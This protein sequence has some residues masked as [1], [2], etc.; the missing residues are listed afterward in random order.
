MCDGAHG[1]P[2]I[3]WP[4]RIAEGRYSFDGEE[5]QLALSEPARANAIHGL[6]RWRPWRVGARTD[7]RVVMEARLLPMTG[8]PF[9]LE[10]AIS[11]ALDEEGLTVMTSATNAGELPCPLG[12]G[13]HPYLSPGA[14][15]R[16]DGCVLTLAAATR[17]LTDE[18]HQVPVSREPVEGTAF[19]FRAGRELGSAS[20]DD[21]FTELERDREGLAR[22]QLRRPDGSTVELWVDGSY[23]FLEVFT[24]DTLPAARRRRGL[25]LEPMSCAPNAFRSGEGLL[26]LAPGETFTGS[27]GVRLL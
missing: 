8:Y 7:S 6:L 10:V 22:A 4:N 24:G 27:W 20:L 13:Q 14:G 3:P 23:P 25:A 21:A 26:T 19:D 18:R 2:L 15:Q 11:Y 1:A 16:I 9:A 12:A 5:Q 17:L